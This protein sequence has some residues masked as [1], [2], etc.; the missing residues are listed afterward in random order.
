MRS[1]CH[2]IIEFN[3]CMS[4]KKSSLIGNV[5][6]SWNCSAV[7][8]ASHDVFKEGLRE[9]RICTIVSLIVHVVRAMYA[10]E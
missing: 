2:G 4:K 6:H 1:S 3:R 8:V 5:S 10:V 7:S 9:C